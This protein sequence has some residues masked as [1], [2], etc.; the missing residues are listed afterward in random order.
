MVPAPGALTV[1]LLEGGR[2]GSS[3]DSGKI[4]S[5][6]HNLPSQRSDGFLIF[7]CGASLRCVIASGLIW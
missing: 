7:I 2:R 3:A 6:A 1:H 4:S 5:R